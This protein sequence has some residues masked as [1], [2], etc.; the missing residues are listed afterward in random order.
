MATVFAS[1]RTGQSGRIKLLIGSVIISRLTIMSPKTLRFALTCLAIL[2]LAG[3]GTTHEHR[4]RQYSHAY[5][6]LPEGDQARLLRGEIC[7]GDSREAVYIALGPPQAQYQIA[8]IEVWEYNAKQYP[9]TDENSGRFVT[10]SSGQW[11]AAWESTNGHLS[12][13]FEDNKISL[14]DFQ[15]VGYP[16][17]ASQRQTIRLPDIPD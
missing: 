11:A 15:S 1:R 3:C 9:A 4:A 10:P 6:G 13:E 5:N 14:W 8:D 12:I 2:A 7:A 16:L 17:P